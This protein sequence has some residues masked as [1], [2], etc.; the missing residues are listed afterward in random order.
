MSST[1]PSSARCLPS[2]DGKSTKKLPHQGI[3]PPPRWPRIKKKQVYKTSY[4]ATTFVF[5]G[6][7][8]QTSANQVVVQLLFHII[9]HNVNVKTCQMSSVHMI[10]L[11]WQ[12]R[13]SEDVCS[14]WLTA[15]TLL[16]DVW[17][18]NLIIIPSGLHVHQIPLPETDSK[19]IWKIMA[20]SWKTSL[21]F[22][23]PDISGAECFIGRSFTSFRT[24]HAS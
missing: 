14:C 24:F 2:Y 4:M 9:S 22:M 3:Y 23:W 20:G 15:S 11:M 13:M 18:K 10:K 8:V 5:L 7:I 21:S 1:I 17:P 16:R 6:K 19:T 12:F